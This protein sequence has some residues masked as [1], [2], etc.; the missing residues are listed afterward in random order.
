MASRSRELLGWGSLTLLIFAAL[1]AAPL[2]APNDPNRLDMSQTLRPPSGAFPF[3]TDEVGRDV[4]S[5]VLYG[6]RESILA[7]F[8]VI[9]AALLVGG[10]V[11]AVAAWCGGFVDEMLMRLTDLFFA[12]PALLL[13]MAIA[14]ALG[15]G[16]Q[17]AVLA[18]VV[19]WWPTYARMMRGAVVRVQHELFVEA[20]RAIG[21]SEVQLLV[22]H[23]LPHTWGV[24]NAR[25][26]VDVGYMIVFLAT[27][28]FVGLGARAPTA[29]WGTMIAE[30]RAYFLNSWWTMTFPGLALFVTV[31]CLNLTGDAV[32][33][34]VRSQ[35]T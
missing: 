25:A 8:A 22:R 4:L 5:R 30:A 35:R 20:G 32:I 26:T 29:E 12:F 14:A 6:G 19:V 16:L 17:S 15:P 18:A 2:V 23:V 21:L 9:V 13:A 27:L 31:V 1:A 11:G 3:G 24:L 28:G 10:V 33:D 7:A 34:L